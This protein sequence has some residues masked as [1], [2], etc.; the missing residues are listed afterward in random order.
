MWNASEPQ[1]GDHGQLLALD[2]WVYVYGGTNSERYY[3]GVYV[4][5]VPH[6]RQLDLNAYEYW[7][8][9]MF[10]SERFYHPTEEQAVLG[11]GSTQGT[12]SSSRGF[13]HVQGE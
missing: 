2:D 7:N 6:A 12:V 8:G 10:T 5:R 4:M 9:K 13:V 11:P 3:D 1:Y